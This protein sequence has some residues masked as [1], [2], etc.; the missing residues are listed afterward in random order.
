MVLMRR[1]LF[2]ILS[3]VSLLLCVATCALWVRSYWVEDEIRYDVGPLMG[4]LPYLIA[5]S[6]RGCLGGQVELAEVSPRTL[7]KAYWQYV[8]RVNPHIRYG[9]PTLVSEGTASPG[10]KRLDFEALIGFTWQRHVEGPRVGELDGGLQYTIQE[11]RYMFTLPTW[12][13]AAIAALLPLVWFRRHRRH[14]RQRGRQRSGLC[15]ACGC[16]LRATPGR[17]PECGA[18]PA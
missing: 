16:D 18:V 4:R 14:R 1:R 12:V 9:R 3:A 13:P 6:D 10:T 5:D 17:C 11:T 2:A 7:T 15:P 8:V